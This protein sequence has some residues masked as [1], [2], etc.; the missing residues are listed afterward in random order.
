[1]QPAQP[2]F[3]FSQHESPVSA[4]CPWRDVIGNLDC[5]ISGDYSGRV[6]VWRLDSGDKLLDQRIGTEKIIALETIGD[7]LLLVQS[8]QGFIKIIELCTKNGLQLEER[9][10]LNCCKDTFCAFSTLQTIESNAILIASIDDSCSKN[11]LNLDAITSGRDVQKCLELNHSNDLGMVSSV[12]L[13]SPNERDKRIVCVLVGFEVGQM[14]IHRLWMEEELKLCSIG[15]P[16][17]VDTLGKFLTCIDCVRTSRPNCL[18]VFCGGAEEQLFQLE[19][20][21]TSEEFELV[22]KK[23]ALLT[24]PGLASVRVRPGDQRLVASGGWDANVRLFSTKTLKKLAV[25]SFHR[26]TVEVV[27]FGKI[28]SNATQLLLAGSEDH[29]ITVWDVYS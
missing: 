8:R 12:R 26:K 16:L 7:N 14:Q 9:T 28:R 17:K 18:K 6:L 13:I 11:S 25:L 15:S 20:L 22:A 24:N 27:C 29:L 10:Q 21:V 5:V 4:L 23:A 19:L 2:V 3:V 1:M